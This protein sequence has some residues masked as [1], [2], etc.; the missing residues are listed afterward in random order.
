MCFILIRIFVSGVHWGW[1]SC[2]FGMGGMEA[3]TR[4]DRTIQYL[5]HMYVYTAYERR[6]KIGEIESNYISLEIQQVNRTW[7]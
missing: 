7:P 4:K 6:R 2:V 1:V 5:V 3:I